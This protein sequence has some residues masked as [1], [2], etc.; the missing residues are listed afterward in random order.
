MLKCRDLVHDADALLDG[1]LPLRRRVALRLHLFMCVHC[2][3]YLRQ[4]RLLVAVLRR[5]GDEPA[6]QQEVDRVVAVVHRSRFE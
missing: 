4:L 5:R 1:G 6:S 3:R 2:R